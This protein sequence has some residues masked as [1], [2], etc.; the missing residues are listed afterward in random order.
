M[1]KHMP[2]ER[3]I[4]ALNA[5]QKNVNDVTPIKKTEFCKTHSV[6]TRFFQALEALNI[7]EELGSSHRGGTIYDWKH[8]RASNEPESYLA[9]RVTGYLYDLNHSAHLHYTSDEYKLKK[10]KREH[11]AK[12]REAKQSLKPKPVVIT[13]PEVIIMEAPTELPSSE[14]RPV[15]P[16]ELQATHKSASFHFEG[17][18]DKAELIRKITLLIEDLPIASFSLAIQY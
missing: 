12:E 17:G 14:E 7:V 13:E 15:A 4:D 10:F 2:L 16:T 8:K 5:L 3:Y 18:L 6:D 11:K 9:T 1:P